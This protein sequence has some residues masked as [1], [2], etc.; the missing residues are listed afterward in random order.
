M[1][2]AIDCYS[3]FIRQGLQAARLAGASPAQQ[4]HAVRAVMGY[5]LGSNPHE[6]PVEVARAVQEIVGKITG[7]ADPYGEVRERSNW[8]AAN[9]IRKAEKRL[10]EDPLRVFERALRVAIAGNIIDFGPSA[11]HDLE[12]T[13]ER[14]LREPLA[15]NH[16]TR[17]MDRLE[18]ANSLAYIADNA[19]E[20]AFD[21]LLLSVIQQ[22]F[23][24][25][26]ILFVVRMRPFLNDAL[27]PDAEYFGINAFPNVEVLLMDAGKPARHSPAWPVWERIESCD[28]RIAKGQANAEAYEDAEDFF[29]LF[30]AKCDLVARA[31]SAKGHGEV[32]TGDMVLAHTQLAFKPPTESTEA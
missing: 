5:L 27:F 18:A 19:G 24:L 30:M 15:I 21:H 23:E 12:G 11:A 25:E 2:T 20:I 14:C 6:S 10:W 26:S 7:V 31:I 8:Q 4:D 16:T 32:R 28:V 3:C 22:R 29:L 17:L 9:W 13:L 1:K